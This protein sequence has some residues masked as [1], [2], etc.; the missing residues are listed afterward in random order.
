MER[1]AIPRPKVTVDTVSPTVTDDVS[2]GYQNFSQWYNSVT[3]EIFICVDP[4]LGAAKWNESGGGGGA[5]V[6][7][8]DPTVADDETKGFDPGD[9]WLNTVTRRFF[10]CISAGTGAADWE[11]RSKALGGDYDIP[12]LATT[13]DNQVALSG[14]ISGTPQFDVIVLVNHISY[15]P[16]RD[17]S[18]KASSPC[19][20]SSDGGGTVT[21]IGSVVGGADELYWVGS[22][23]GFELAASDRI[24]LIYEV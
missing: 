2:K 15:K 3:D 5:H 17:Q 21:P 24:D 20:F 14:T 19:Y 12:A 11:D 4:A 9:F 7:T 10:Q 1:I 16:A 13:G 22:V 6:D 23:A 8:V 18:E